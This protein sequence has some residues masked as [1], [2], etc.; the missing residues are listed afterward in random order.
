MLSKSDFDDYL[1][2][3]FKRGFLCFNSFYVVRFH[4]VLN[5]FIGQSVEDVYQLRCHLVW[6]Q[7]SRDCIN[8][9][10]GCSFAVSA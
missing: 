9:R 1:E 4:I 5:L 7:L 2:D 3:A 10:N 8:K 6:L